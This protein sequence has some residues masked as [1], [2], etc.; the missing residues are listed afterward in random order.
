MRTARWKRFAGIVGS[1][2]WVLPIG[3]GVLLFFMLLGIDPYASLEKRLTL[4][5]ILAPTVAIALA[6]ALHK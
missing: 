3:F 1:W 2:R 4:A 5:I 6:M